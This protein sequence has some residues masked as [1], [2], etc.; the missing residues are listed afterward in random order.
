MTL[1]D[2]GAAVIWLFVLVYGILG[3]IDFGSSYWR[4]FFNRRGDWNAEAVAR[5]YVS[6]TWELINA[7]LVLI[8]V[9]LVGLFPG[10]VFTYGTVLLVPATL[11]LA[12]LALRGAYWQFGYAS[13]HRQ[14]QTVLVVG[15]TGLILPGVLTS[16]LPL[17]QGGFVEAVQ[18]TYHL[19]LSRFFLS[20]VVY[21]YILFGI[22]LA[23]YVSAMFLSRYAYF[24]H[25]YAAY[26]VY[27]RQTLWAGPVSLLIGVAATATAFG[28]SLHMLPRMM[29]WWPLLVLSLIAFVIAYG[30]NVWAG[31]LRKSRLGLRLLNVSM[32]FTMVQLATAHFTYGL[33]HSDFWLYPYVHFTAAA[34]SPVM[35]RDTLFVLAAGAVILLPGFLWFRHLFI[36]D[37]HYAAGKSTSGSH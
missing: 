18:G 12:L 30:A 31:R 1:I 4:W 33:A 6:P 19:D 2:F 7:F 27:R 17:S 26:N 16:L 20:P 14:N 15:I 29:Q 8:P 28:G 37:R 9:T 21:L 11:L 34:S 10:A 23:L 32:V 35:F 22:S 13:P 25:Q 24:S 3:A 36:T 5:N